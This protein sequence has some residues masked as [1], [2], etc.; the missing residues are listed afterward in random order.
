MGLL[1]SIH[2]PPS[3]F[4]FL[5]YLEDSTKRFSS[6]VPGRI[7]SPKRG[8]A[9]KNRRTSTLD[10]LRRDLHQR[11]RWIAF[12]SPSTKEKVVRVSERES[13]WKHFDSTE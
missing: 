10:A 1:D 2:S 7:P 12:G 6:P 13:F 9:M 11:G 8:K 4:S 3:S 5:Y